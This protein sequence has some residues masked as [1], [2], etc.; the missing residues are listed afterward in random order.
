MKQI[1]NIDIEC[2][3]CGNT[4][5]NEIILLDYDIGY[6]TFICRKCNYK[7]KDFKEKNKNAR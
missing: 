2:P 6:I 3:N 5:A 4:N 7:G 1:Q